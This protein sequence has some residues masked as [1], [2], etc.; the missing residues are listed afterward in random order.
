MTVPFIT[1]G[2]MSSATDRWGTPQALFDRLDGMF[3]FEVDVCAD[4][5]N[6]KCPVYFTKEIDGL[7]QDWTRFGSVFMNPP[8]GKGMDDWMRK[9]YT[10]ARA[11]S[12]CVCVIPCRTD[13]RWWEFVMRSSEVWL[14]KG[15]LHYNDGEQGAPFPSC[16]VIYRPEDM[17]LD[18]PV[19]HWVDQSLDVIL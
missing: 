5:T 8:Y 2:T 16:V 10:T 3:H 13:T 18:P 11:G 9:I 12:L 4:D 1:E 7:K 6:H 19:F 14:I 15:R 17:E